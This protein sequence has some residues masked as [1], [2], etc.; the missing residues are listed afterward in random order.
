MHSFMTITV[1]TFSG[2]KANAF[3]LSFAAFKG[4][5]TG[6]ELLKSMRR[7][8]WPTVFSVKSTFV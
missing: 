8:Y 5:H 1:H 2:C 3:L 7:L 4:S 6:S